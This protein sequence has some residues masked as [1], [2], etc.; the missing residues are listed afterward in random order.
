MHTVI[1]P[2]VA[3]SLL[4]ADFS[5]MA[6]G[7]LTAEQAGADWIHLDVMDGAF[8]PN[9]TFGPKMVADLRRHTALPLDVHL[10]VNNPESLVPDFIGA[11]ADHVT[12]HLEACVHSHRLLTSIRSSGKKAGISIVPSTPVA[13]LDELL[14]LVDI[15]LVMTVN[16]G[17]GGQ[18]LIPG[19]L[20]KVRRLCAIREQKGYHYSIEVDGGVNRKTASMIREAGTD[21][22]ISGS[23]FFA[24]PSPSAEVQFFK[25]SAIV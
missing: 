14:G 8:V 20:E 16:P 23:A 18:S 4:S 22:L 1:G 24:S 15:V 11:G 3:A 9:L 13:A 10:M 6:A 25:G 19:C 5:N 2:L 17:F 12:I 7:V 21:V